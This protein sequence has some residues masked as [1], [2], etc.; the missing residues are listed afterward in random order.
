MSLV[1]DAVAETLKKCDVVVEAISYAEPSTE[2]G[3]VI[4]RKVRRHPDMRG[5]GDE[6]R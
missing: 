2:D 1:S 3:P 6:A 4:E 5:N